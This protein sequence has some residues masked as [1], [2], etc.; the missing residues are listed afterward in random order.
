MSYKI[1]TD[2][3]RVILDVLAGADESL[4]GIS[5]ENCNIVQISE[6]EFLALACTALGVGEKHLAFNSIFSHRVYP[7]S[8]EQL[9]VLETIEMSDT[10]SF[11]REAI[12]EALKLYKA[13]DIYSCYWFSYRYD[14]ET[15]KLHH[16]SL[17]KVC[18]YEHAY[19][20]VP[21]QYT[22]TE[23][24]KEY[25]PIW[26]ESHRNMFSH[27]ISPK[28]R[29]M[30]QLYFDSYLIGKANPSFVMLFVVLEMLYGGDERNGISKR[31]KEG[32]SSLIGKN[33][34]EKHSISYR[35]SRLYDERSKYVH[36]GETV[37]WK[38]LFLLRDY[39]RRVLVKLYET[40]EAQ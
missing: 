22:L 40:G 7:T 5:I 18:H 10:P 28:L 12:L 4:V 39:V 1:K 11:R 24:E 27:K 2:A 38:S 36:D 23:T 21:G 29:E 19:N 33:A 37:N 3:K 35:I 14:I 26:F 13:A 8:D 31:I 17:G 20:E 30:K 15:G 6:N 16:G 9:I 25:F 34:N 32:V